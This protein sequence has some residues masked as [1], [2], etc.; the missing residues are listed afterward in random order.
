VVKFKK[1]L[2]SERK[3]LGPNLDSGNIFRNK[4]LCSF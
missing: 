2:I 3:I 1:I 4:I